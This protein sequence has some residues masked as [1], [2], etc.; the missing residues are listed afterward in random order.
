MIS[1]SCLP[2]HLQ[3]IASPPVQELMSK[4]LVLAGKW[5]RSIGGSDLLGCRVKFEQQA[6]AIGPFLMVVMPYT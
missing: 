3:P 1:T 2:S 6:R 5:V 4:V